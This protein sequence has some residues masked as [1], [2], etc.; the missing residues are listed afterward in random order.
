MFMTASPIVEIARILRTASDQVMQASRELSDPIDRSR[1]LAEASE[2]VPRLM[3]ELAEA[4]MLALREALEIYRPGVV[5]QRL[6]ISRSQLYYLAGRT[7]VPRLDDEREQ[8]FIKSLAE[9]H[10]ELGHRRSVDRARNVVKDQIDGLDPTS[11][12]ERLKRRFEGGKV[13]HLS[14]D[15]VSALLAVISTT[16]LAD[17]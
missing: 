6:G 5:A 7:Q 4:R 12:R 17:G 11:I 16:F 3:S 10:P 2:L 13:E 15:Q 9:I 1:E 8:E 14:E